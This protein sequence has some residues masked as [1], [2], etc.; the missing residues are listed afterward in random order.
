MKPGWLVGVVG[1][2]FLGVVGSAGAAAPAPDPP[3][4]AVA[5]ETPVATPEPAPAPAAA[6]RQ[7][8]AVT[9][10]TVVEVPVVTRPVGTPAATQKAPARRAVAPVSKQKPAAKPKGA[11]V[12]ATRPERTHDRPLLPLPVAQEVAGAVERFER[13]PLALAGAGLAF[14]ALG[15]AVVLLATRRQLGMLPR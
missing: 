9:R 12:A 15:G 13:G 6:V 1:V 11:E 5:P 7:A 10:T 8:P 14:V 3:P 4:L 2:A